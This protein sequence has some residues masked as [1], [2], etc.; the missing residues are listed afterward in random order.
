M[1]DVG[2]MHRLARRVTAG[3][4]PIG[5][6]IDSR[7][8]L[9]YVRERGGIAALPVTVGPDRPLEFRVWE[10]GE[11]LVKGEFGEMTPGPEAV[12]ML[13]EL[14][15]VPLLAYDLEGYRLGYGGGYYDRTLEAMHQAGHRPVTIGLAWSAQECT[16]VPREPHDQSLDY[17]VT[18]R[19]IL[20]FEA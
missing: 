19:S 6:E 11:R 8:V 5:N 7:P 12:T 17:I 10:P 20:S 1:C 4:W 2:L 3:F 16:L 18:E 13:P 14:L 15:L 9:H